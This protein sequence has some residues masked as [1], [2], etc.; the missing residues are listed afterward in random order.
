VRTG[1]SGSAAW[2][3][4]RRSCS[5]SSPARPARPSCWIGHS[6]LWLADAAAANGGTLV[7]LDVDAARSDAAAAHLERAGLAAE[8]RVDDAANLLAAADDE[9]WDLVFLDAERPDYPGYWPDLLRTLRRGGLL[10][11]DNVLSHA[12]QLTEFTALVEGEPGVV[13]SVVETGAGMRL[14]LRD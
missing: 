6:T 10:I 9:S 14:I 8:L 5:G 4:T 12:D 3:P 11:V 1:S 2:R 7:S 13:S